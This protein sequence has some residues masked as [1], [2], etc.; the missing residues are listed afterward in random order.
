MLGSRTKQVHS[1]GRRGRRIV[2][3]SVDA[4]NPLGQNLK[5]G[6]RKALDLDSELEDVGDIL[7]GPLL[8]RLRDPLPP[9]PV[10]AASAPKPVLRKKA[11]VLQ[12]NAKV[13][14]VTPVRRPLVALAANVPS[15]TPSHGGRKKDAQLKKPSPL[16]DVDIIILDKHGRRVSLEKRVSRSD[17]Q[18]NMG[19]KAPL[20]PLKTNKDTPERNT[21]AISD[22]EDDTPLA[23]PSR[24]RHFAPII[25]SSDEESETDTPR[26]ISV[27]SSTPPVKPPT[28]RS[29]LKNRSAVISP[30]PS[31]SVNNP[32]PSNKLST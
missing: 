9:S 2:N 28:R 25:I 4:E 13:A 11:K 29:P 21:I 20:G 17:V 7:L 3:V 5:S 19:K 30:P 14:A 12:K 1:Y 18:T 8:P 32:A 24:K 27:H 6:Y 10:P 15:S 26:G 16:V 22:S 31:P 23:R